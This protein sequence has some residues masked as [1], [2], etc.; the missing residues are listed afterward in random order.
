MPKGK[1]FDEQ[2][3]IEFANKLNNAANKK[4]KGKAIEWFIEMTGI[5]KSSVHRVIKKIQK[6]EPLMN[7]ANAKQT[8]KRRKSDLELAQEKKDVLAL[9]ALKSIQGADKK[10]I[11]TTRVIKIGEKMGLVEKGKYTRSTLDRK[12]EEHKVNDRHMR[13]STVARRLSARYPGHVLAIDFTPLDR[14]YL[15]IDHKIKPYYIKD[16]DKH[17][18]DILRRERLTKIWLGFAVDMFS[19]ALLVMPYASLPKGENSKNSG[20][21]AEDTL[22][23]LKFCCLP[24]SNTIS[25]VDDYPP[26]LLDCPIEGQPTILYT[27]KGSATGKSKLINNICNNLGIKVVTHAS[28]NPRAKLVESYISSFKR[29]CEVLALPEHFKGDINYLI[30]FCQSWANSQNIDNGAYDKWRE[31]VK[32]KPIIR[33]TE[34]NFKD[35]AVTKI[36]R[37]INAWGCISIDN[38]E[39]FV[40][41]DEQWTKKKVQVYRS[42]SRDAKTEYKVMLDK[43]IVPCIEAL[44]ADDFENIKSYKKSEGQKN[45]EEIKVLRGDVRRKLIYDDMLPEPINTKI[46]HLPNKFITKE[47]HTPLISDK[48]VSVN[49]AMGW[50]LTQNKLFLD[51]MPEHEADGLKTMLQMELDTTGHIEG[52]TVIKYSNILATKYRKENRKNVN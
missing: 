22:S 25:P 27:D 14:Y 47:V 21:N 18:D 17:L 20:E 19:K 16:G 2:I 43:K 9:A 5:S 8:R 48:F 39:F 24:K 13:N 36:E 1:I 26:P 50:I 51:D 45:R 46:R 3:I 32:D 28:G 10:K 11:P 37:V 30:H 31:G 44:P 49:S 40:T 23:F 52:N 15:T 29:S 7:I 34:Q 12:F 33:L 38:K 4:E 6:N 35:A 42:Y 41:E